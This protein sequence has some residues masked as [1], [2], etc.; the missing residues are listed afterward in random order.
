MADPLREVGGDGRRIGGRGSG[1]AA[2]KAKK[3]NHDEV[4]HSLRYSLLKLAGP[5]HK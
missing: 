4:S 1:L 3:A 2:D 5:C